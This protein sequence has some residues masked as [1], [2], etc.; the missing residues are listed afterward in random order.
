MDL[1]TP[2]GFIKNKRRRRFRAK[3]YKRMVLMIQKRFAAARVP[4]IMAALQMQSTCRA[5]FLPR[6]VDGDHGLPVDDI[7]E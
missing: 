4:V 5:I 3:A 1:F 7:Q 6:I 2:P